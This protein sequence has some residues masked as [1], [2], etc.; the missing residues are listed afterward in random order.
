MNAVSIFFVNEQVQ[1]LSRNRMRI[2][3]W[4]RGRH[5][6]VLGVVCEVVE[7]V[8]STSWKN[9]GEIQRRLDHFRVI[10]RIDADDFLVDYAHHSFAQF[11][12]E[13]DDFLWLQPSFLLH[14][15]SHILSPGRYSI[16]LGEPSCQ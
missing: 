12:Q 6:Y 15:L 10:L 5:E 4:I 13:G 7:K 14:R 2:P 3:P 8:G 1:K 9:A 11:V 16:L